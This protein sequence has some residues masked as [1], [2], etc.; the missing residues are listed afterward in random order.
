MLRA[1]CRVWLNPP[2]FE[3]SKLMVVDGVWAMVGS[4]NWDMRSFR[5]NFE[6]N[7]EVVDTTL[8]QT[9]DERMLGKRHK[10]LTLSDIA[11][12]PLPARIRDAGLR[13]LLPYL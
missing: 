7:L 8:A 13:L 2:P 5:L 1:G 11:D 12:A 3:H 9:L 4:A 6:V 10:P